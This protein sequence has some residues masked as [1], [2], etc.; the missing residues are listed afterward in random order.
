MMRAAD[1][2][3]RMT[4]SLSISCSSELFISHNM[5]FTR[6]LL[7]LQQQQQR[8]LHHISLSILNYPRPNPVG[9]L[10]IRGF[11][12]G[13]DFAKLGLPENASKAEV[14]S[15]YFSLAK[16]LH[17]DNGGNAKE[18]NEITEAYKR[19]SSDSGYGDQSQHG[20][21]DEDPR[22][23]EEME[24]RRRARMW[25]EQR[26][27]EEQMRR[28]RQ[29]MNFEPGFNFGESHRNDPEREE[30]MKLFFRS[31]LFRLIGAFI[32]LELFVSV[33]IPSGCSQ[34]AQG[35]SCNKCMSQE[36]HMR[37]LGGTQYNRLGHPRA[38]ECHLC[39]AQY[40]RNLQ[41]STNCP[42]SSCR[43]SQ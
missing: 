24:R 26:M 27:M 40:N 25:M 12:S 32:V 5:I 43:T 1:C 20:G 9:L 10:H 18:F 35:C 33:L 8:N 37:R 42:C 14:K 13:R 4:I 7:S 3:V 31:N 23:M 6:N 36:Y 11:N 2:S 19:L 17:P 29:R 22:W 41:H 38:C 39:I 16:K 15:A 30:A 34:Y 21:H 28:R